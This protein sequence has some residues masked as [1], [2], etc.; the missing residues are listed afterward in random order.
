MIDGETKRVKVGGDKI[1][2]P[3]APVR[4]LK[5]NHKGGKDPDTTFIDTTTQKRIQRQ[6][7]DLGKLPTRGS[8]QNLKLT[9]VQ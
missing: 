6:M 5:S 1:V 4:V 3:T 2:V 7:T 9:D 8:K